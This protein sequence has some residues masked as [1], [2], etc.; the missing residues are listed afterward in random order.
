VVALKR[1]ETDKFIAHPDSS[2]AIV[3]LFGPDAGLVRERADAILRQSV[4]DRADPFALV[5]L[6]GEDLAAD[7]LR[8]IDEANTVPLFGG[9][10]AI[11]VRAGTRNIL[12]AVEPLLDVKIVDCRIVIEAG[13]LRKN[14]PLRAALERARGAVVIAR[15]VFP[16]RRKHARCFCRCSAAIVWR[17]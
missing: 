9:R 3:L 7:P 12:A 15:R 2:R 8:L 14:A 11:S 6:S 13:D 10:R 5:R 17:H 1:A 4:D 16:S